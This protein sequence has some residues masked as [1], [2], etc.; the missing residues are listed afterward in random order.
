MEPAAGRAVECVDLHDSS[1]LAMRQGARRH[2]HDR[3]C[4]LT[5]SQLARSFRSPWRQRRICEAI[6]VTAILGDS[7]VGVRHC[8]D[9]RRDRV[10]RATWAIAACGLACLLAAAI[11]FGASVRVAASDASRLAHHT[12]VLDRPAYAFRPH[13]MSKLAG[14]VVFGGLALGLATLTAALLRA[15]RERDRDYP[16]YRIGTA[17][18]VEQPL[19]GAPAERFPLIAPSGDGFVFHLGPGIEG[20]LIVGDT[21]TPLSQLVATGQARLSATVPGAFELAI[22]PSAEI[23]ARVGRV[24]FLVSSVDP[25][26][27]QRSLAPTP[28]PDRRAMWIVAGS[29]AVHLAPLALFHQGSRAALDED[30]GSGFIC[31]YSPYCFPPCTPPLEPDCGGPCL[32]DSTARQRSRE[33]EIERA[34]E[35]ARPAG[36][37]VTAR[38]LD[39]ILSLA[40]IDLAPPGGLDDP[41]APRPPPSPVPRGAGGGTFDQVTIKRRIKEHEPQLS[42]CYERELLARPTLG[43]TV[44]I[45]FQVGPAGKVR[46]TSSRSFDDNVSNVSSC[47]AQVIHQISFPAPRPGSP[48]V[49]SY[50]FTFRLSG[51]RNPGQ[52]LSLVRSELIGLYQ[53]LHGW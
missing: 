4:V 40:S 23:L 35:V 14:G 28:A 50:S 9:P 29:L 39:D 25:P 8:V 3:R 2:A 53:T 51:Y 11:T 46:Q 18:G 13:R 44:Q 6:E 22:P 36:I 15:G 31:I 21:S 43:G 33:E 7:I 42:Y 19:E 24:T 38:S 16:G 17:P 41:R 37:F 20:E 45:L 32:S 30:A 10:S 47:V 34:L 52:R 12:R 26:E 5:S 49:V 1:R 27:P 48:A